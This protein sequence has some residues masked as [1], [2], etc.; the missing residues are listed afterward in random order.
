MKKISLNKTT[1]LN[2]LF[3]PL[4]TLGYYLGY[5]PNIFLSI[6]IVVCM[7]VLIVD[8]NSINTRIKDINFCALCS[9]TIFSLGFFLYKI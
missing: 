5:F 3:L 7:V 9:F 2:I 8:K 4:I 6:A 1:I